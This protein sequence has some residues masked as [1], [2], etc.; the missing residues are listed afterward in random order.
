LKFRVLLF[1]VVAVTSLAFTPRPQNQNLTMQVD[2]GISGLYRAGNWIP[3][4]ITVDSETATVDGVLQVRATSESTGNATNT[5]TAYQTPF[6]ISPQSSKEVFLYI[7]LDNFTR[8]IQVELLDGNGEVVLNQQTSLTMMNYEDVMWV[9]VTDSTS[10]V[11]DVS[12]E[13]L[14]S[15][16]NYQ[17]AW[18]IDDIPANADALRSIDFLVF[19][20][21]NSA[22]LTIEQQQ[23]IRE[24]VIA[25][26]HL[27]VT[28]GS[29]W[30]RTTS[31]LGDLLPTE[32]SGVVTLEDVSQLE[33]FANLSLDEDED[34]ELATETLIAD[35]TPLETANILLSID[36]TPLL[37]RHGYGGGWVD[38]AAFDAT[39]EPLRSWRDLPYVWRELAMTTGSR[40]SWSYGVERYSLMRTAAG[41]V[42]FDL[43]S[44]LQI[45][46]FLGLYII[47]IG[48]VNYVVLNLIRRREFAWLTIPAL[49]AG[50]TGFA[51]FTGFSVRGDDVTVSEL[52]VVQLWDDIDQAKV[53]SVFGILSP[54]RTTY[55]VEMV[56]NSFNLRTL[57]NESYQESVNQIQIEQAANYSALD[58]PVDAAIM[59]TF[60]TNG[61]IERPSISGDATLTF[62]TNA[63]P[64]LDGSITNES[65]IDLQ[66][67][68]ILVG[69]QSVQLGNVSDGDDASF[70]ESGL[71]FDVPPRLTLGNRVS[72]ER[73]LIPYYGGNNV[74]FQ[75]VSN[76][77]NTPGLNLI[78]Q[79]VLDGQTFTCSGGDEE[80]EIW[81]R[82]YTL[83]AF[84]NELDFNAGRD[85]NV[86]L[87]AWGDAPV[88]DVQIPETGQVFESTVLYVYEIPT[89]VVTVDEET[90][91][92]SGL[93]QWSLLEQGT[94]NR[95]PNLNIQNFQLSGE[96][97]AA[98]R[99]TPLI[100][101]NAADV[102]GIA[103]SMEARFNTLDVVI[104]LW[105]WERGEWISIDIPSEGN[106]DLI[107]ESDG[108]IGTQNTVQILIEADDAATTQ[109]VQNLQISLQG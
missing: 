53:D 22:Q 64:T 7:S 56:D 88:V 82:A 97:G 91:V 108:F 78:Y 5:E 61:Y 14:S 39:T 16:R 41:N 30:Q 95:L 25:G 47:L 96:Q 76:C 40:P 62:R 101:V 50:F 65:G 26:G 100:P 55:N 92:P 20:D 87:L 71:I 11:L 38:F 37:V 13:A 67:A 60:T 93:M 72:P 27:I 107:I 49:I 109:T 89:T 73:P 74:P 69:N 42:T 34:S 94:I 21:V 2:A 48:P 33:R 83:Q 44:F 46:A 103:V 32:P 52:T 77:T 15:G 35:N 99:F 4:K 98:L 54:R 84:N 1:I 8:D 59:T 58:I 6:N 51:Y 106:I 43:P 85:A 90:L 23:A 45:G 102:D 36:E 10:G 29:N 18:R 63:L 75:N 86:Y 79:L 105:H 28:G 31:G 66:D 3:L 80:Q 68:V 19:S 9:V 57:P 104:S 12:R 17:T 81:R 24:W 70:N